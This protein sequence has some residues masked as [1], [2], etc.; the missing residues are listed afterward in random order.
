MAFEYF[1]ILPDDFEQQD[2][3]LMQTIMKAKSPDD[4]AEDP[5]GLLD[6]FGITPNQNY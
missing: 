6:R 2:F 5:K 1:H 4:R 3:F